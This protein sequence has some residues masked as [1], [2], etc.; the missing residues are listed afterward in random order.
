VNQWTRLLG[1]DFGTV[2]VGLAISDPD[3]I[4]ASA[5]RVYARRSEATDA[6][7]FQEVV[8]EERIGKIIV[9][10]P[11]RGRG[12]EGEKAKQ[13]REYGAWLKEVTQLPLA[14][15]DE[16]FTTMEAEDSMWKAGMTHKKRQQRRDMLAAQIMLQGYIDA[17]CP[18]EEFFN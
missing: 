16:R 2:R 11:I 5:L 15:Y 9:G 10:L 1:I 18:E 6:I 4:I 7:F 13:A 12:E 17:G 14:F 3:R 8:K